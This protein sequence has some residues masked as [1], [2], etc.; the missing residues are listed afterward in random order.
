MRD[1][2]LTFTHWISCESTTTLITLKEASTKPSFFERMFK[3][4]VKKGVP[5]KYELSDQGN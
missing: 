2:H 1:S 3:P 5:Q 4:T